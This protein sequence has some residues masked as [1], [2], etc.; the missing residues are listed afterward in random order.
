MQKRWL[1]LP[2]LVLFLATF[3]GGFKPV[4]AMPPPASIRAILLRNNP[5]SNVLRV[6]SFFHDPCDI[7]GGLSYSDGEGGHDCSGFNKI[8]TIDVSEPVWQ[9]TTAITERN[10]GQSIAYT[11][12]IW[13]KP[14]VVL[15]PANGDVSTFNDFPRFDSRTS[16]LQDQVIYDPANFEIIYSRIDPAGSSAGVT[17]LGNDPVRNTEGI[18]YYSSR[19]SGDATG[20]PDIVLTLLYKNLP[21]PA[22]NVSTQ[23]TS[24]G[25]LYYGSTN[26]NIGQ[27][28]DSFYLN[29]P[30]KNITVE[31]GDIFVGNGVNANLLPND[32]SAGQTF[33]TRNGSIT[34]EVK[35]PWSPIEQRADCQSDT[36]T[37]IGSYIFDN[38][39][40]NAGTKAGEGAGRD[41][42]RM[43]INKAAQENAQINNTSQLSTVQSSIRNFLT[44]PQQLWRYPKGQMLIFT[45][46][47][48]GDITAGSPINVIGKKVVVFA[49]GG[50][51]DFNNLVIAPSGA[52]VAFVGLANTNLNLSGPTN[53]E[54][55]GASPQFDGAYIALDITKDNAGNY[56]EIGQINITSRGPSNSLTIKGLLAATN[57]NVQRETPGDQ[58]TLVKLYYDQSFAQGNLVGLSSLISPLATGAK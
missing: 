21:S 12:A 34:N 2:Y 6:E 41:A 28:S 54:P 50:N 22:N 39:S 15:D 35:C 1:K 40:V 8:L 29:T 7:G 4:S 42:L 26:D 43:A 31:Q 19:A 37:Q 38:T 36:L 16:W 49:G 53:T 9:K 13:L 47:V 11:F 56:N 23:F 52:K 57:I 58:N 5:S 51:I 33:I 55:G 3:F 27:N 44:S 30:K 45:S 46:P 32:R 10:P 24:Q 25:N 14:N 20:G 48:N 17:L 18:F